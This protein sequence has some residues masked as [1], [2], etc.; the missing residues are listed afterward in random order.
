[1]ATNL[2][3]AKLIY[4]LEKRF[5]PNMGY[6]GSTETGKIGPWSSFLDDDFASAAQFGITTQNNGWEGLYVPGPQDGQMTQGYP[7]GLSLPHIIRLSIL[8]SPLN[9]NTGDGTFNT[10]TTESVWDGTYTEASWLTYEQMFASGD[11]NAASFLDK[12]YVDVEGYWTIDAQKITISGWDGG[13]G[14]SVSMT[15]SFVTSETLYANYGTAA[16]DVTAIRYFR[17]TPYGAESVDG[18][19]SLSS[20]VIEGGLLDGESQNAAGQF[21]G[22]TGVFPVV[23]GESLTN[24]DNM[25]YFGMG[26]FNAAANMT[27]NELL[28]DAIS[29]DGADSN[30]NELWPNK[31]R[32]IILMD[33]LGTDENGVGIQGNIVHAYIMHVVGQEIEWNDL[34][35]IDF[36]G[37]A[38]F[39]V[40]DPDF[41]FTETDLNISE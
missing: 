31:V 33:S 41:I 22:E 6:D 38:D 34:F 24:V 13:S 39:V 35:E 11:P 2:T 7:I 12:N 14:S 17:G 30:L 3:N 10:L 26:G 19:D 23:N 29:Y 15:G 9:Y 20:S 5:L 16:M 32:T 1:M 37:A 4:L 21:L 36:D 25:R 18:N 40:D 28:T 27:P 8:P